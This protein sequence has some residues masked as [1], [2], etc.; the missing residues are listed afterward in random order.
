MSVTPQE[1]SAA[2]DPVDAVIAAWLEAENRGAAPDPDVFVA[3]NPEFAV[4]LRQFFVEHGKMQG[5]AGKLGPE[6]QSED[7]NA[8][9]A[10]IDADHP[11]EPTVTDSRANGPSPDLDLDRLGDYEFVQEIARG[12]MGVVFKG[13]DTGIG[14]E[15]AVK[16]LLERHR[17]ETELLQR[18]VEEAQIAGQLQHPG[19]TPV[20]EMGN[21]PD[22]RPYFTMKLVKG[23]TLAQLLRARPD[24]SHDRLRYLKIFEQVCQTVAYAHSRSVI[25]RDLKPSNIMVGAFGE[26]QVMDWG[27]GKVLGAPS[28]D[29]AQ[30]VQTTSVNVSVI[31]TA[32]SKRAGEA[33]GSSSQTQA[34]SILGTP[35]YMPPEQALGQ[36]DD[37]DQRADVFGLGAILCEILTGEPPYLGSDARQVQ[38]Q[39]IRADLADALARLDRCGADAQLTSLARRALA[40]QPNDRPADARVMAAE[41]TAYLEGVETRLRQAELAETQAKTRAIE[42]RR[43]RKQAL[44]LSGAVLAVLVMGVIGT[45]WGLI[46][47]RHALE[48]QR[49][50]TYAADVQLAGQD[51]DSPDGTAKKVH[52]LLSKH[53]PHDGQSDLRDFAWR[54][55]WTALHRNSGILS[56]H[57]R[58]ARMVAVA[59]DGKIVTLDGERTLR[60]WD[61]P[62]GT[63]PRSQTL[64]EAPR[65]SCWAIAPDARWIAL[66]SGDTVHFFDTQTGQRIRTH[67]GQSLV[68]AVCFSAEGGKLAAIWGDGVAQI[69]EAASGE[70]VKSP[71][72][73]DV[74]SSDLKRVAVTEDGKTLVLVGY[75][76]SKQ[77]T[78]MNANSDASPVHSKHQSTVH[79]IALARDGQRAATGDA[80]GE[81]CVWDATTHEQIGNAWKIHSG[82]VRALQFS[83]DGDLLA[84][85]GGGRCCHGH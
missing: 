42:E 19:V 31:R 8:A 35:A 5:L 41:M 2:E 23:E 68:L 79:S 40:A 25:H 48:S 71:T 3:Q 78:W 65:V 83:A 21:L 54:L 49:L 53:V 30:A 75:P 57:D 24:P 66:G 77:I 47:V 81:I 84:T 11:G 27:L 80:N 16:V 73:Q 55:Q 63:N 9:P 58:G 85:G 22:E 33:R 4:E 32:R 70:L 51:W 82:N 1:S 59:P 12:G 64:Q 44:I 74:E 29:A 46:R 43:R 37:L 20:Y 38:L 45:T 72:I 67:S 50:E 10:E 14:R 18:F 76:R 61:S 69:W 36:I 6:D 56:G 39:A 60:H 13:R 26:V 7:V 17:G 15:I 28:A 52:D 34:G 62:A